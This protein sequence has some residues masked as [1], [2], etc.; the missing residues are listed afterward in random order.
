MI[1]R[2]QLLTTLALVA[3]YTFSPLAEAGHVCMPTDLKIIN[4]TSFISTAKVIVA[5]GNTKPGEGMCTAT[6]HENGKTNPHDYNCFNQQIIQVLCM[7]MSECIADVYL[8]DNCTSPKIA[9]V[10]FSTRTG[11]NAGSIR[12]F[13][14][15]YEITGTGFEITISPRNG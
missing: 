6:F 3:S 1:L 13:S 11:V 12:M 5:N 10:Y 7:M 2:K 14:R 15:D 8:N 9:T 4:N